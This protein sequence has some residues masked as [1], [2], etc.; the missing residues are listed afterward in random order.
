[1]DESRRAGGLTALT[2][3]QSGRSGS[4]H[5]SETTPSENGGGISPEERGRATPG[6]QKEPLPAICPVSL[7]F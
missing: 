4:I 3:N 6:A 1:M 7:V 5:L 2:V